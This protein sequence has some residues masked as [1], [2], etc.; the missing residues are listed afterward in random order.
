MQA[1]GLPSQITT[2]GKLCANGHIIFIRSE[3]NKC[4]G[5]LKIGFK[6]LFIR[7]RAGTIVEMKP[8][9]VLDFYVDSKVQRGG[10]GRQLFDIMLKYQGAQPHQIAYDRPSHK[11]IGFLSKHF[12]LTKHVQ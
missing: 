11:L 10:H 4:I 5:F 7:N 9:S 2:T 6:K 1:Q 8:L 3:A 12:G